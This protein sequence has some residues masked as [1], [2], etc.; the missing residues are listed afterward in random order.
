MV[1]IDRRIYDVNCHNGGLICSINRAYI[2]TKTFLW[3]NVVFIA[4]ALRRY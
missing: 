4:E 1:D 2:N 3:N